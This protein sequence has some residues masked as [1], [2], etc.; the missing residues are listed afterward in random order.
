MSCLAFSADC[1]I[2]FPQA[3]KIMTGCVPLATLRQMCSS[4]AFQSC[5][6]H[7]LKMLKKRYTIP[8]SVNLSQYHSSFHEFPRKIAWSYFLLFCLLHAVGS[9]NKSSLSKNALPTGWNTN[10]S[11]RWRCYNRETSQK[12]TETHLLWT[13]QIFD[14]TTLCTF[15][16][17][18]FIL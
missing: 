15:W 17:F 4:S 7:H 18:F 10:R 16:K 5:P 14:I 9:G 8:C 6:L 1:L 12:Q 3:K 11:A 13:G 2:L